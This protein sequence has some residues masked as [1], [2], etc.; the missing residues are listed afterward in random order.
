MIA[1]EQSYAT[2]FFKS[3]FYHFKEG[4]RKGCLDHEVHEESAFIL[5]L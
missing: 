3:C 2:C 1:N 5:C 4:E